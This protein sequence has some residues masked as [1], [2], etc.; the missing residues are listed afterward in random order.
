MSLHLSNATVHSALA[1]HRIVPLL[2]ARG[3]RLAVVAPDGGPLSYRDLANRVAETADRLGG[4][5]RLMLLRAANDVDSLV[6]YLAALHGGHPVLLAAAGDRDGF[7]SLLRRYDPDVVATREAGSW[8]LDERRTRSARSLHPELALLLS[9]SGSTGSPKLAR[10]SEANVTS[11]AAAIGDN[12]DIRDTDRAVLSLPMHYCYGL[13]VVNSN[14]LR[15]A[16]LL[17]SDR[18]VTDPEYFS[19]CTEHGGTSLHGVPY[20]FELLDQ[21]GFEHLHLPHL[22]YVTQ[23]GGRLAPATVRRYAELGAQRGWRLHVMYGATEATARMAHLPPELAA[24]NPSAVGIPIP[25]GSFEIDGAD[26][27]GVG[28]LVYRGPNVMLGYAHG[29]ADLASGRTVEALRTGDLARRGENGLYEVVGRRNRMIKMFGLRIDL[30]Q[31]ERLLADDGVTAAATGSD[32]GG[33]VVVVARGPDPDALGRRVA[34]RVGLPPGAVRTLVVEA[35]PRLP[36]GKIDHAAVDHAALAVTSHRHRIRSRREGPRSVRDAFRTVFPLP[37]LPDDASFVDLGG[38]S[39]SYVQMSVEL[40]RV[41]GHLPPGWD[42]T[43]IAQLDRL[44]RRRRLW[45]WMETGVVLRAVAIV[46]IV[47]SHVGVFDVKG[48]AHLLLGV[49]GWAFARFVLSAHRDGHGGVSAAV[50]R[51]LARI[52]VPAVA[53]IAWRSSTEDDLD[54]ANALLANQFLDP[55][56]WGYWYIESV[57]QILLVLAVVL[58]V[59]AVRRW[60]RASPFVFSVAV[61]LAALGGRLLPDTGNEFSDRLMSAHLVAWL[62]VL[63]WVVHRATTP[64]QR[65]VTAV[66]VVLSVPGFF[67]DPRRA[68]VVT[69]GLLLLLLVPRVAVPRP[70]LRPAGAV[71]GASL[72]IYLTHYALYPELLPYLPPW[73]VV[74]ACVLAGVLTWSVCTAG[75]RLLGTRVRPGRSPG[76]G[77]LP[78]PVRIPSPG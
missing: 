38:D 22:R 16:A 63:G 55:A 50:L 72:A 75:W 8:L 64:A 25:G 10:L 62:F 40:Q 77:R 49:S 54:L 43:P 3:G 68:T 39:L 31:V 45:A 1:R 30:A 7:D 58:A 14:L 46:L 34:E 73:L 61:L 15:G 60:E 66:L 76:P 71:A 17:M 2:R 23:A 28:E 35:L 11:N 29:P 69:T 12:L 48:G 21:A 59:P 9:T 19:T 32:D 67:D 24:A 5:R 70:L 47:G 42:T 51:G 52:A 53:W 27:R 65:A 20:T 41:L 36:N 4:E 44:P 56:A 57:S 78:E 6:T 13:S 37:D 26:D 33:L 74:A 18:S